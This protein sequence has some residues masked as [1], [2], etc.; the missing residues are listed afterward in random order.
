[1]GGASARLPWMPP[2]EPWPRGASPL[3]PFPP[4]TRLSRLCS[5]RTEQLRSRVRAAR[6]H[7]FPSPVC[8]KRMKPHVHAGAVPCPPPPSHPLPSPPTEPM[9]SREYPWDAS[10]QIVRY[11]LAFAEGPGDFRYKYLRPG[12][13]WVATDTRPR[14]AMMPP[15]PGSLLT[16]EWARAHTRPHTR[17][18]TR[19]HTHTRSLTC[20]RSRSRSHAC[21]HR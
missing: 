12:H 18:H 3:P 9:I 21:T 4:E 13:S 5:T 14:Q 7:S 6:F 17:S 20:T 1:M 2:R 19:S 15:P 10:P 8:M 16:R 11:L